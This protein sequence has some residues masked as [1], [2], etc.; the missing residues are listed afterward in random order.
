M[1]ASNAATRPTLGKHARRWLYLIHRWIGITSCLF[2]AMWFLSGLVMVYVPYPSLTPVERLAGA[3]A[4]GWSAV[5]V[6]PRF[7]NGRLPRELVLEMRDGI[8]VWRVTGW[9]DA[10]TTVAASRGAVLRPVDAS[11]AGRVASRFVNAPAER[12][13]RLQ[14]DQWTVGGGFDRHRP[15]WKVALGDAPGTEVYVSSST[16]AVVQ[17]T[18]RHERFWNWLGSVPHWLY[19]TVLRQDQVAWRQVVMWVS[20]ACIAAAVTG[21]W[22]GILRTRVGKRRFKG[23]RVSPYTGWM[24]W[25]HVAGL[26]G[27][28]FLITWIFSGWLS[29]DPGHLFRGAK[30]D[31]VAMRIY[32]ASDP[33]PAVSLERLRAVGKG[34]VKAQ[35]IDNAGTPLV[36][37]SYSDGRRSTLEATTF[38]PSRPAS[39]AIVNAASRLAGFAPLLS[40]TYLT[41]PDAYWYAVGTLPQLPVLRLRFADPARSWMY[42]DVAT[43]EI[44]LTVDRRQRAYRW[45]FDLLHKWDLNA[46]TLHRPAW[47]LLIWVFSIVGIVTS[48]SG[49]WLGYKRLAR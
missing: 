8:A 9:D 5:N 32:Q 28:A 15:L 46:L 40:I 38:L 14:R 23:G 16:G 24:L 37:L 22:I 7:D 27:G 11:Y 6:P 2:F 26:V 19:P 1:S 48:I 20:G 3:E 39:Q 13:A 34:A 43:G 30:P 18:T 33:M 49:V 31:D 17:A 29:V 47:D 42:I 4:I 41:S 44:L 36:L 45:A 35:I 12:V 25:H 10:Q 21:M